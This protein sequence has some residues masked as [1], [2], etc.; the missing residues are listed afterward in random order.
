MQTFDKG[1][2]CFLLNQIISVLGRKLTTFS[3]IHRKAILIF[4]KVWVF[5]LHGHTIMTI[6]YHYSDLLLLFPCL[7]EDEG[8]FM[9]H[10]E[11]ELEVLSL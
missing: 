6:P 8:L 9:E 2:V 1:K 5:F 7:L 3:A 11:Q 4:K 10:S